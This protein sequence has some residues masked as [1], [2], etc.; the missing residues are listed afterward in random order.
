MTGFIY[1]WFDKKHKRYYVGSHWGLENDGYICSSTWMLQAY[2][3]RPQDFK[4]RLLERYE[5][6]KVG[7]ELE[8]RWLQMMK[9]EE[10]KGNRYYNIYN[11]RFGH[12]STEDDS[13]LSAKEKLKANHWTKREDADHI[14]EKISS[15]SKGRSPPNKGRPMSEEAKKNLSEKL[16]GKPLGYVRSAETKK[17]LSESNKKAKEDM[18]NGTREKTGMFGKK[19][20]EETKRKMSENNAM[21]NPE[22]IAAL[23]ASKAKRSD[24]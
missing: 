18:K 13:R 4:R 14:R 22:H 7:N 9:I 21:K 10:L 15:A 24:D 8:H 20:S 11:Y 16:K 6:R 23:K 17:K 12:W 19:H 1:I 3:R 2:K 5:D